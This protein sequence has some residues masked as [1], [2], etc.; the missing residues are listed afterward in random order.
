LA[1]NPQR[2]AEIKQKLLAE[3]MTSA[4]FDTTSFAKALE[5]SYLKIWRSYRSQ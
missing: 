5:S 1:S 3:K 2:L 4:L